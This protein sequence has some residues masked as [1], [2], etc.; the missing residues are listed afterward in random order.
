[1]SAPDSLLRNR[2]FQLLVVGQGLSMLGTSAAVIT[3]PLLVLAAT[4]SPLRV[5]LVEAVWTG[6]T[7]VAFL[8]AG[9]IADRFDRR[10]VML[11]CECGRVLAS[12]AFA[13]AISLGWAT[14]PVLFAAGVVFGLL[15]APHSAAGLAVLRTLVPE[16]KLGTALAVNR[17]RAHA[18]GLLGPV[19]GG[20]LFTVH[21]SLPFWLNAA[22]FVVS[23]SSVYALRST[24]DPEERAEARWWAAVRTGLRFVWRDRAL[25]SLTLIASAQN[26]AIEGVSLTVVVATVDH[27]ASSVTVGVLYDFWAGGALVGAV[28]APRV[29]DRTSHR[30]TLLGGSVLCAL[31]VPLMA[32]SPSPVVLAPLLT[33]CGAAVA[34]SSSV[35]VLEQVVR[36]PD[37]LQGR[38]NSTVGLVL[39]VTPAVGAAVAGLL[40]ERLPAEL[41]YLCFGALLAVL[42][43]ATARESRS[44]WPRPPHPFAA[45]SSAAV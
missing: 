34:V 37:H 41:S 15:T 38:M 36:T 44:V 8:A 18:A 7:A 17:V 19:L 9:P 3:L 2:D 12:A 22:S 42:A 31:V 43:A 11:T 14:M 1:M 29:M 4:G 27:G 26:F 30:R 45:N 20:F 24:V 13:L 40:L 32:V 25:R 39:M 10:T 23:A 6:A 28:L 16:R 5:G 33:L 35:I 21:P